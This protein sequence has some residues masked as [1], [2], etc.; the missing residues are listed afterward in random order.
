VY[1]LRSLRTDPIRTCLCA[2]LRIY[3]IYVLF[4]RSYDVTWWAGPAYMTSAFE[5]SLGI[6]C[7]CMPSLKFYF[8]KFFDSDSAINGSFPSSLPSFVSR[9]MAGKASHE[10]NGSTNTIAQLNEYSSE[11]SFSE[12]KLRKMPVYGY[13]DAELGAIS[14]TQ[15][16]DI[17]SV[18]NEPYMAEP[19]IFWARETSIPHA[20]SFTDRPLREYLADNARV[21]ESWLD[22]D[23]C[24]PTPTSMD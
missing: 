10:R 20:L 21:P 5:S 4:Y 22:E 7:A 2:I 3:Y 19:K 8:R 13:R 14:V 12:T 11:G 1:S 23:S 18:Y 9:S 17:E 24:P 15:E 16:L 6:I